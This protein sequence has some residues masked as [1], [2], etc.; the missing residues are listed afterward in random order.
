MTTVLL[1]SYITA[2][3]KQSSIPDDILLLKLSDV[4]EKYDANKDDMNKWDYKKAGPVIHDQ[5][6]NS[7]NRNAVYVE[8][9][10]DM[11]N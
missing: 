7:L 6:N 8:K 11:K 4:I 9:N 5:I 1:Q 10:L 3:S 2:L